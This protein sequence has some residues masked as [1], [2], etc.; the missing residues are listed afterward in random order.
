[1]GMNF[2]NHLTSRARSIGLM[3][4]KDL[5]QKKWKDREVEKGVG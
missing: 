1:M 5:K 2:E 4:L 3:V